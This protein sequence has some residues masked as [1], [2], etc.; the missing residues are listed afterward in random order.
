MLQY[1]TKMFAAGHMIL[2]LLV[3]IQ[4]VYR[5]YQPVLLILF[6]LLLFWSALLLYFSY[7]GHLR[8][9]LKKG[10]FLSFIMLIDILLI[11][12]VYFLPYYKNTPPQW[13][14]L[15]I[16]PFYASEFGSKAAFKMSVMGMTSILFTN[17]L[18]KPDMDQTILILIQMIIFIVFIGRKTDQLYRLAYYDVL[19]GLP[20][21]TYMRNML[22]IYLE[23]KGSAKKRYF[24][25]FLIDLDNFKEVNDK[26]GH[27][28]GDRF[29]QIAA[30]QMNKVVPH[31]AVISRMGGDEF[32]VLLPINDADNEVERLADQLIH[33]LDEPV[34][35]DHHEIHTSMSL[36]IAMFPNDGTDAE[37]IMK[38]ADIAMYEAKNTGR[39]RYK[40]FK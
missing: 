28:I 31:H 4:Y 37:T 12:L 15:V 21:R 34:N 27:D 32:T 3:L 20:N 25:F 2:T 24:Y 17:L 5:S 13:I 11:T 35:I 8:E 9:W 1:N 36:G 23:S 6:L 33:C 14:I 19:T 30:D 18:R 29:L 7:T 40:H 22:D 16:I 10:S 39:N 38:K 26:Y